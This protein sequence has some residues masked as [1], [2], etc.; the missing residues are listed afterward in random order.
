M[1]KAFETNVA[2]EQVAQAWRGAAG[3]W[4][5][6]KLPSTWGKFLT[7]QRKMKNVAPR[8]GETELEPEVA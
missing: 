1:L 3:G 7:C 2:A 5:W 8:A 4:S 6:L